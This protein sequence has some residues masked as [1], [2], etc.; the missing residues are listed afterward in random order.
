MG[1]RLLGAP[2]GV[3]EQRHRANIESVRALVDAGS[4]DVVRGEVDYGAVCGSRRSFPL[5]RVGHRSGKLTVTGY[6]LGARRGVIAI[7]VRC[8]CQDAEY[9]VDNNNF[10]HFKSTRC[11]L[12]AKLAAHEKRFWIYA[13]AMPDDE[14]RRRLLNRL[15]AAITRCHNPKAKLKYWLH[16]GHRGISV[17]E[18]WRK[19][20]TAFLR[21][22]QT[23]PGWDIP[24]LEMDRIDTNGNYE[25]GNIRFATKHEN[26]C[27]KRKVADLEETIASLRHRLCGAEEQ[28]HRLNAERACDRS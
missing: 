18:E 26:L 22:V 16:Y 21:Y 12:C 2:P 27:N 13:E 14:H 19:D 15:S 6:I 20:R 10:R 11:N 17:Y 5:P 25:P 8:D 28:I 9:R 4:P 1:R 24:E 3:A 23:L 7:I